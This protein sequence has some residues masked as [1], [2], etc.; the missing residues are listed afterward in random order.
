VLQSTT[1]E[2]TIKVR[3]AKGATS[4]SAA[5]A[6]RR[7][8]RTKIAACE[9]TV[10]QPTKVELVVNLKTAKSLG[11]EMPTSILLSADVVIE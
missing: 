6:C 2:F 10:G 7:S 11:L 8:D 4:G 1:F 3:T 5:R 9:Q